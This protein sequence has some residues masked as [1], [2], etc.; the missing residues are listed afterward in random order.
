VIARVGELEFRQGNFEN[1]VR[2]VP[3]AFGAGGKQ[4]EEYTAWNGLMESYYLLANYDSCDVY[5]KKILDQGNVKCQRAKIRL[6][7]SGQECNGKGDYESAKDEFLTT[8]NSA[9]DE[10]GAEAQILLAEIFYLNKEYKQCYETLCRSIAILRPMRVGLEN[11]TCCSPTISLAHGRRV[12]GQRNAEVA[13]RQFSRTGCQ[14]YRAA[15]A[16]CYR[17]KRS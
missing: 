3:E 17:S 16:A 10:N 9:R 15:K 5:A 8:L 2:S 12:P 13:D 14:R 11:L 6:H 4:E 7:C 1:A